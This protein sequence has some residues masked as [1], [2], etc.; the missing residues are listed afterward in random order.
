MLFI[1]RAILAH[2][3]EIQSQTGFFVNHGQGIVDLVGNPGGQP[4]DGGKFLIMLHLGEN[5]HPPLVAGLETAHQVLHQQMRN[6]H[7]DRDA[8]AEHQQKLGAQCGP[9]PESLQTGLHG[10]QHQIRA[11]QHGGGHQ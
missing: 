10:Q 9:G 11:R 3:Q 8:A 4:A 6:Q 2:A 1:A 5:S 7:N